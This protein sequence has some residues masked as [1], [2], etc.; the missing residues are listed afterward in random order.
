MGSRHP[1]EQ[2]HLGHVGEAA[3]E[4]PGICAGSVGQRRHLPPSSCTSGLE[5]EAAEQEA[6]AGAQQGPGRP[7]LRA[8]TLGARRPPPRGFSCTTPHPQRRGASPGGRG[9]AAAEAGVG[10]ALGKPPRRPRDGTA[11]RA[12]QWW[13]TLTTGSPLPAILQSPLASTGLAPAAAAF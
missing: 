10:T 3:A 8:A 6:R 7:E 2:P 11:R 5:R 4:V 1:Q 12:G 9:G 13:R